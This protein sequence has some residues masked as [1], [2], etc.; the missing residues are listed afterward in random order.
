MSTEKEVRSPLDLVP[1]PLIYA[2]PGCV[3]SMVIN[4]ERESSSLVITLWKIV[5]KIEAPSPGFYSP[6]ILSGFK[7]GTNG[8][9]TNGVGPKSIE[10]FVLVAD[11][12]ETVPQHSYF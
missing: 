7:S 2:Y 9:Q 4:I 8:I 10:W 6:G 11:A 3:T 12:R 5:G 1:V